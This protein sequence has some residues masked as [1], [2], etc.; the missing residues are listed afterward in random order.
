MPDQT[1]ALQLNIDT[2]APDAIDQVKQKID[3]LQQKVDSA[4]KGSKEF[5]DAFASLSNARELLGQLSNSIGSLSPQMDSLTVG[6]RNYNAALTDIGKNKAGIDDIGKAIGE[7]NP[8]IQS[9]EFQKFGDTASQAL[10]GIGAAAILATQNNS[11]LAKMLNSATTAAANSGAQK[12]AVIQKSHSLEIQENENFEKTILNT[13]TK[14]INSDLDLSQRAARQKKMIID[15][16][17]SA[18]EAG[19]NALSSLADSMVEQGKKN[20]DAQKATALIK[21]GVDTARAISSLVAA[22]NENP[23]NAPTSG[24][25]G[26]IQFATGIVEILA[27]VAKAKDVLSGGD[28][29]NGSGS[30]PALSSASSG[31]NTSAPQFLPTQNQP[32]ST[33]IERTTQSNTSQTGMIKAYV[34][35]SEITQAQ[36]RATTLKNQSLH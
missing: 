24:V 31:I 29:S 19:A 16:E 25:A 5:T 26:A 9:E 8:A 17:F 1:I 6:A 23:A 33:S 35:E 12:L 7:I 11:D 15:S 10:K 22:S 13:R 27:N 28:A 36:R 21:I 30:T 32:G 14:Y 4:V 3:E 18:A 20:T 2:N 34:V